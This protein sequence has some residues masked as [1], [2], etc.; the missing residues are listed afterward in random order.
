MIPEL[1]RIHVS[2]VLHGYHD[3][4]QLLAASETLDTT[5]KIKLL[6]MS[7]SPGSGF[8]DS[9]T[10]CLTGYSLQE[11]GKYALAKTWPALQMERPGCVWTHTILI[12]FSDLPR[13]SD[14]SILLSYFREPENLIFD[15]Y[16]K[17]LTLSSKGTKRTEAS[18]DDLGLEELIYRLYSSNTTVELAKKLVSDDAVLKVW[19]QQW[20]RLR[21]SFSFRTWNNKTSSKSRAT[22]DLLLSIDDLS[23][24]N[25]TRHKN[26]D[27]DW[28]HDA[29]SDAKNKSGGELRR[30]LWKHGGNTAQTREAFIPLLRAWQLSSGDENE[31]NKLSSLLLKW[32]SRPSS[33]IRVIANKISH[34]DYHHLEQDTTNLLISDIDSIKASDLTRSGEELIGRSLGINQY[35]LLHKVIAPWTEHS[36]GILKGAAE[37]M[38]YEAIINYLN[39]EPQLIDRFLVARMDILE[40]PSFWNHKRLAN[41]AIE[42]VGGEYSNKIIAAIIDSESFDF[43]D[44][45]MEKFGSDFY[46]CILDK[47]EEKSVNKKWIEIAAR[48]PHSLLNAIFHHSHISIYNLDLI[49]GYISPY[50]DL[51]PTDK[52]NDPW[53]S[54]I[55]R[56]KNNDIP[57]GLSIFLL[58]RALFGS[59]PKVYDLLKI[60][61]TPCYRLID[62]YKLSWNEWEEFENILHYP[63][64]WFPLSRKDKFISGIANCILRKRYSLGEL[65]NLTAD[66]GLLEEIIYN[67][68][69]SKEGAQYLS[70]LNHKM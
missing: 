21:R 5:A 70:E 3:G 59:S 28:L 30:F 40:E 54:A 22:F 37:T 33:I 6:E 38:S 51:E 55:G 35:D 15:D 47:L 61:I 9:N 24:R 1:E 14:L 49:S 19:S 8:N 41:Q 32:P 27:C 39:A 65:V 16:K 53:I 17:S 48:D 45:L 20:P 64:T 69:K 10:P 68:S 58:K 62:S 23:L 25:F 11:A 66:K 46:L 34:S 18:G 7:N 52:G 60:S 44:I 2:Q 50:L 63:S 13:I 67:I 57:R 12:D 26:Q 31:L 36:N 4:H 42:I 56:A 43:A 29:I